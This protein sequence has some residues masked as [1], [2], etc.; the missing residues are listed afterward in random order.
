MWQGVQPAATS[1]EATHDIHAN[2]AS[3]K[4]CAEDDP[5]CLE[6]ISMLKAQPGER[7][8][9]VEYMPNGDVRVRTDSI[10]LMTK[11]ATTVTQTAVALHAC[12]HRVASVLALKDV[13]YIGQRLLTPTTAIKAILGDVPVLANPFAYPHLTTIEFTATLRLR[14]GQDRYTLNTGDFVCSTSDTWTGR[15][16]RDGLLAY[17]YPVAYLGCM[18]AT[19][20][21]GARVMRGMDLLDLSAG[22]TSVSC[23]ITV[24]IK[25]RYER[26]SPIGYEYSYR[27]KLNLGG[28][29]SDPPPEVVRIY[30]AIDILVGSDPRDVHFSLCERVFCIDCRNNGEIVDAAECGSG[31]VDLCSP[32]R[33]H[34]NMVTHADCPFRHARVICTEGRQAMNAILRRTVYT[35]GNILGIRV[36]DAEY[37]AK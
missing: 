15:V 2:G 31:A 14:K 19:I 17:D 23:D 29:F 33:L 21:D 10:A 25:A 22:D 18:H 24:V 16:V 6:L 28:M 3:E 32:C 20:L 12:M 8:A 13:Q 37:D 36:D 27:E 7:S 26:R 9:T 1:S 11:P 35:A 34:G 5:Q 4:E 30:P